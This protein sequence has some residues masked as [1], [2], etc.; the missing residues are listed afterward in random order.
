[1]LLR[2]VFTNPSVVCPTEHPNCTKFSNPILANNLF[3]QNR[4]FRITTGAQGTPGGLQ[5]AVTLVP[6]LS[7]STTGTCPSGANYWDI[8]VFGDTGPSNHGS[9]FT[10]NPQWSFL[11]DATDYPSGSNFGAPPSFTAQYC[12]GSR[13]APEIVS[14]LCTSTANA[15]GCIQPGTVGIQVPP[16]VPDSTYAGPG[17]SLNPSATVDEGSNWINMLYG[18]LSLSNATAYK[19]SNTALPPLGNYAPVAGSPAIDAIPK[20]STGF[21]SAPSTDFFGN[22]RPDPANRNA[23]DVGAVEYQ[24]AQTGAAALFVEPNSLAFGNVPARTTSAPQ[25]LTL[26]NNGGATATGIS[27]SVPAPFARS[28]GSCGATLAA[29][30]SCTITIVFSPPAPGAA[31]ANATISANVVVNGSPVALTG[32]G[33]RLSVSPSALTFVTIGPGTSAAQTITITNRWTTATGPMSS[34]ISGPNASDFTISATTC[35]ASLAP[36]ASCTVSV[37]FHSP[38]PGF[39]NANTATLTITDN[40]PAGSETANVGLTGYRLF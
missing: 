22:P 24:G 4:S 19:A 11:S 23:V 9:T 38:T 28:G 37:R 36:G 25:T 7:Q 10:L 31:S 20:G 12:N 35:G 18:P 3:W 2:S 39:L 34:A 1:L 40:D 16:G 14:Q 13:I 29:A 17:F 15:P 21:S 30:A 5:T 6:Q 27:V 32:T 8:G 33:V 26:Y